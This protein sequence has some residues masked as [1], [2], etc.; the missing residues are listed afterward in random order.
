VIQGPC[1]IGDDNWIGPHVVIGTPPEIRGHDHRDQS[2]V[3][4]VVVG[5]RGVFREFLTIQSGVERVTT[6]GDDCYLMTKS[7][8]G[9]DVQLGVGVTISCSVSVGG[10]CWIGDGAT[11]G[12][13]AVLHQFRAV[14]E[15]A[16]I[17]M[18]SAIT[19]DVPP[20]ALVVGV[21][22]KVRGANAVGLRRRG[23]TDETIARLEAW[24]QAGG[25]GS[26]APADLAAVVREFE[27][28]RR[29]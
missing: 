16:M 24:L 11:I 12:L 25:E 22:A 28:R 6:V 18:Q 9:H 2:A 10:H 7:H 20:Y 29:R 26:A 4:G 27:S 5:D 21:P 19:H 3:L 1:T 14:G 15:G 8:I 23:A 13:G 17:G